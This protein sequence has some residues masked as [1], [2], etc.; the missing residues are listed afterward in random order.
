MKLSSG[1]SSKLLFSSELL[2]IIKYSY[3]IELLILGDWYVEKKQERQTEG[4]RT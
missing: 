1:Y 4:D 3:A 2:K